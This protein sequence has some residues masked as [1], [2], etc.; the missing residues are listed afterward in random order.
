MRVVTTIAATA[1]A[2]TIALAG[3]AIEHGTLRGVVSVKRAKDVPVGPI[4]VYVVGFTEPAPSGAGTI[5]QEGRRFV[6]DLV[7]ITA[8]QSVT[9]P[10]NDPLLHNVF[11]PTSDRTFDLG[12]FRQHDSRSRTFPDP[13][14]IEVYCN[15]HP[16]M[17]ATVVVVPNRKFALADASGHFEIADVPTGTW[18][19]FAYSR[20]A[21]HPATVTVTVAPNGVATAEL[22]LDEV[23]RDFAQHVNKYG[24]KYRET[25]IYPPD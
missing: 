5:T 20:R 7:A 4:L 18:R 21:V 11:S 25:S 1:V 2:A 19:V 14:V 16:E 6:P 23:N 17:S 3:P 8:G 22:Q 9:F 15:I 12:S 24:E 13:G 10:N